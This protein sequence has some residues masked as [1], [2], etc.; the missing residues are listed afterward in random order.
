MNKT[1]YSYHDYIVNKK[2]IPSLKCPVSY[3]ENLDN[4]TITKP[5]YTNYKNY[6][7]Y[8]F[9]DCSLNT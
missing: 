4:P 9:T 5:V 3:V 6:M 7:T 8:N 2:I 1:P